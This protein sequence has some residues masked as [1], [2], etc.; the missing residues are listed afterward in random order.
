MLQAGK[1]AVEK[2]ASK[3]AELERYEVEQLADFE[4]SIF[5]VK[6]GLNK[7]SDGLEQSPVISQEKN[8]MQK[9]A[10][11]NQNPTQ[12]MYEA[13]QGMFTLTKRNKAAQ[14][15][16]DIRLRKEYGR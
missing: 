14:E 11:S 16:N 9:I 1:I 12:E 3:I 2:L 6:K 7:P 8:E 10:S 5:A 13:M 15:D 4:K